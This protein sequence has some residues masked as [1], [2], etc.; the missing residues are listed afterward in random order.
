MS[1][2][3][4]GWHESGTIGTPHIFQLEGQLSNHTPIYRNQFKQLLELLHGGIAGGVIEERFIKAGRTRKGWLSWPELKGLGSAGDTHGADAYFG[5]ARRVDTSSGGV[6]N[7]LPLDCLWFEIDLGDL[8]HLPR[9]GGMSK[10]ELLQASPE[11]LEDLKGRL[12]GEVLDTCEAFEL[13]PVAIVDSGHGLHVYLRT[14]DTFSPKEAKQLLLALAETFDADTASAEPARILRQP[15]TLNLKNP[16]RPLPVNLVYAEPEARVSTEALERILTATPAAQAQRDEVQ[17][18]TPAPRRP[19]KASGKGGQTRT[20]YRETVTVR[21]ILERNGYRLKDDKYL[22]PASST[23]NAGVMILGGA[24][25]LERALSFN[26]SCPLNDAEGRAWNAYDAMRILEHGGDERA[27]D[28]AARSELGIGG[29]RDDVTSQPPSLD[30]NTVRQQWA[31]NPEAYLKQ[32]TAHLDSLDMHHRAR[33]G[34][35]KM[36]GHLAGFAAQGL[37]AE[38]RGLARLEV[39]GLNGW[40]NK[41]NPTDNYQNTAGKM[42]ALAELGAVSLIPIDPAH[43]GRGVVICL[44]ENPAGVALSRPAGDTFRPQ[45]LEVRRSTEKQKTA[46]ETEEKVITKVLP[47]PSKNTLVINPEPRKRR[48]QQAA[49]RL[50]GLLIAQAV[51][52]KAEPQRLA[53]DLGMTAAQLKAQ[54]L[55]LANITGGAQSFKDQYWAL[56]LDQQEAVRAAYMNNLER[57]QR[58]FSVGATFAK[59]E[60]QRAYSRRRAERAA[61]QLER[62]RDGESPYYLDVKEVRVLQAVSLPSKIGLPSSASRLR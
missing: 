25:G 16:A 24:D 10:A 14:E 34:L 38:W 43:P 54:Q 12:M 13:P 62:L 8:A 57:E 40:H 20:L 7:L 1:G 42:K 30:M 61:A 51:T 18:P 44:P 19:R 37:L 9:F 36:A 31:M 56:M 33:A 27:A 41:V 46:A 58:Q 11:L 52:P 32:V 23:G 60:Q 45:T 47:S 48:R 5:V 28:R 29:G 49:A 26:G 2:A 53:E 50:S 21:E 35:K 22:P 59:T 3:T 39:G 4:S 17:R 15:G 6:G 55:E